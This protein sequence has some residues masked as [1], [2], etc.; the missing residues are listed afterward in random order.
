VRQPGIESFPHI[1][2]GYMRV[3][4]ANDRQSLDL[5]RD[6]LPVAEVDARRLQAGAFAGAPAYTDQG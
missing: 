1:L 2:I 6:A 4:S 5:Q 3:S